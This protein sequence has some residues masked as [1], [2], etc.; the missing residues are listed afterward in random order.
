M[1]KLKI[2]LMVGAMVFIVAIALQNTIA[3]IG[4]VLFT[5]GVAIAIWGFKVGE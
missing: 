2:G 4:S 3:L 5:S 1:E